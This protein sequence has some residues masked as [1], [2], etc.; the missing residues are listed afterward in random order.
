MHYTTLDTQVFIVDGII[1]T[2]T[3]NQMILCVLGL[4]ELH[5]ITRGEETANK[6]GQQTVQV[7][8]KHNSD[9]RHIILLRPMFLP[10][11]HSKY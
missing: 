3:D 5:I 10:K 6:Q 1:F 8:G 7:E 11:Q 2:V 4:I 9:S